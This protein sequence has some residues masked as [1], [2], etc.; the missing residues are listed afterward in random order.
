M[1]WRVGLSTG[2]CIDRPLSDVLEAF[3]AIGGRGVELGSR[4]DHFD[5][6]SPDQVA[7]VAARLRALGVEP[8]SIHAPFGGAADL[9]TVQLAGRAAAVDAVMQAAAA[10][11]RGGGRIVVV[12][13]S[14]TVRAG[15]DVG[16]R[17]DAAA[18]GLR[19]VAE[20]CR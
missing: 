14:D 11:K 1:T 9:S 3:H 16:A 5:T 18:A 10:L 2:A 8:V 6:S 20:R 4:H 15:Q 7:A 12:H 13:P 19:T 17:L